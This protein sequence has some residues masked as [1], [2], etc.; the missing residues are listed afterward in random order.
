M[1]KNDKIIPVVYC[2]HC[3]V[4]G[5]ANYVTCMTKRERDEKGRFI[6]NGYKEIH[7]WACSSCENVLNL[8][9]DLKVIKWLSLEELEKEGWIK[10]DVD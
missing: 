1:T 9:E 2:E 5:P 6:K 10:E 4:T 8:V 7:I 3:E